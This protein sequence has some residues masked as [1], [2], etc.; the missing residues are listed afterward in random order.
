MEEH[1]NDVPWERLQADVVVP[2]AGVVVAPRV[3]DLVLSGGQRFLKLEEALHCA[4]L[5]II[6][7]TANSLRIA[8]DNA[9]SAVA[10]WAG[11]PDAPADTGVRS[12]PCDTF[13]RA[14]F[15]RGVALH[16]RNKIGH[17]IMATLEFHINLRPRLL[18]PI[19]PLDESVE[20]YPHAQE[21]AV[22]Q[23]QLQR[24]VPT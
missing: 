6:S 11:S 10:I 13:E 3:F 17:E 5:W 12:C 9:F 21:E 1:R 2:N 23:L 7:A 18:G 20:R 16:R 15:V 24:L 14:L 19:A 8:P 22:Q 4:Q